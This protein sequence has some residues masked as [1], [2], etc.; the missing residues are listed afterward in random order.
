MA[1]ARLGNIG[2]G[3]NFGFLKSS[4]LRILIGIWI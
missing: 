4:N 3:L 2:F 1:V